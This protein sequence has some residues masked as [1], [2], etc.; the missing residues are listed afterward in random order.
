MRR[1]DDVSS[2]AAESVTVASSVPPEGG[3]LVP[4]TQSDSVPAGQ[5]AESQFV[6]LVTVAAS[7]IPAGAVLTAIVWHAGT[8]PLL[9]LKLT[10]VASATIT[11]TSVPGS[12]FKVTEIRTG[13]GPRTSCWPK[14]SGA[15]E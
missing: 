10:G 14:R 1:D 3:R 2:A 13:F 4:I 9:E 11:G 12:T 15:H 6:V 8:T 7:A 5:L